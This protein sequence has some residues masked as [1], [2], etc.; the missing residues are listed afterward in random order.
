MLDAIST[1]PRAQSAGAPVVVATIAR[2]PWQLDGHFRL[3]H[4][5]FVREQGLFSESDRDEHD[6][7][8]TPIVAYSLIA[9]MPD[10]VVGVVRI[11]PARDGVWFG[12]RLGVAREHRRVGTI[13]TALIVE[14]VATAHAWGARR[15]FATVQEQNVRYFERHHFRALHAVDVCGRPHRLMTADLAAYPPELSS[16]RRG[17]AA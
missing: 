14:A 4:A 2:E 15:F 16:A 3:R 13:G 10:R 9:G 17:R 8:A 11:Y 5:I 7:I 1:L 6:A 12:G